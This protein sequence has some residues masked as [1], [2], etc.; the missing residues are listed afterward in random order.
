MGAA[1]AEEYDPHVWFDISLWTSVVD[2]VRDGLAERDPEHAAQYRQ[3]ADRYRSELEAVD[4]EIRQR[5]AE[6]PA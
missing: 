4:E 2:A 3:R 5:I 6:I 1:P